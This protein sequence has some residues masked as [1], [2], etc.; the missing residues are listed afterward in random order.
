MD[1]KAIIACIAVLAGL[2]ALVAAAVFFLYSGTGETKSAAIASEGRTGLLAAVPSDAVMVIGFSDLKTACRMLTDTSGCFHYFTG[3]RES[4]VLQ[5]FLSGENA[6]DL[7]PLKSAKA[8][9]SLHYNG[10]LVPLMVIDAGRSGASADSRIQRFMADADSCGL[11]ASLL[12]C[13]DIAG[14]GTYLYRRSIIL[15]SVSDVQTKS[16]ARHIAKGI[17]ILDSDGFADCAEKVGHGDNTVFIS[18]SEI[19]KFFTGIADKGIYGYADFLKKFSGWA[20]FSIVQSD[21]GRLRLDGTFTTDKGVEDFVNVFKGYSPSRSTVASVLPSYTIFF[22]GMPL[23]DVSAYIASADAFADGAG[24]L[25][26]IESVRSQLQKSSGISPVQWA[27]TL[28]VKEVAA[29]FFK[30]GSSVEKVLLMKMGNKDMTIVFRDA[31]PSSGKDAAPKVCRYSYGGFAASVFGP[32]FNATEETCFTYMD[33]WIIVGSEAA[34]SEYVEGRA[35]EYPLSGYVTDASI[36]P[37][38]MAGNKY[39]VSYLSV[40]DGKDVLGNI[41]KSA[42]S[43]AFAEAAEGY[44]YVPLSFCVSGDKDGSISAVA[45]EFRVNVMKT[46]APVFER[47]TVVTVPKGPFKVKNSGT[48][49][50]NLFYQQDNMYLC[51]K[52]VG[53][54]GIWGVPFSSPICGNA[55]TIDYFANGKLQILFASGS[56][57]Y[58]IDRLGRYVSPFPVDLGKEILIGPGIYDF[59]GN[60]KYNVMILHKD[61]TI[62]MY[63]LQARRPAQ[64]KTITAKETIKGLPEAVKVA[65]NTYW[66]VRTSIQT[67]IFGFYGG[68][69][70]TVFEGDRMIRS[71]SKVIPGEGASVK[72]VCYD[73]KTHTIKLQ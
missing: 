8:V 15:L 67:L 38:F 51:L 31:D 12:D 29:A 28:G 39:F 72:V 7:G 22:A 53:G 2:A 59:N 27:S 71:D 24:R 36:Q 20:C 60:R 66:V 5:K 55:G 14:S 30:V 26:K 61:N 70:L 3:D 49:K 43:A 6:G 46:K 19:G 63:N 32:F 50:M 4:S 73:G 11:S 10:S 69:P 35:L 56:S 64:W 9:L 52:E 44:S 54:K 45:E 47:D 13:A 68:E 41:F 42:Y 1:R 37:D 62:E 25:G 23:D 57:L 58:L 18:C 33:D 40:K 65:G 48:G 34:V 17:S 16:S 21:S